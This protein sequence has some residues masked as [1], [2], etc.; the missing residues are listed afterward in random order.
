[1]NFA[2]AG[3]GPPLLH[4]TSR[5]MPLPGNRGVMLH[6]LIVPFWLNNAPAK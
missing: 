6:F 3:A 1:M 2:V 5:R 4:L